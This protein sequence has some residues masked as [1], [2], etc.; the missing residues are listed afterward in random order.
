MSD[1]GLL[2][3]E[4]LLAGHDQLGAP[5]NLGVSAVTFKLLP[6]DERGPL[7]I[8]NTFHAKGGPARHLHH[9]QDEWFYAL[10]GAFVL[11]VGDQRYEMEPGDSIL[12]PRGVSHVWAHTSS[13]RGRMLIAFF[14]AGQM[15]SF[16]RETGR[17]GA[18]PRHDPGFWLAHG[19]ELVGPPV[20]G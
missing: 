9:A 5:V 19:M 11:E 6:A 15:E 18:M 20:A 12:A 13:G 16:F 4:L 10:E 14:P 1:T 2:P 17:A 7:I 3:G 8:E